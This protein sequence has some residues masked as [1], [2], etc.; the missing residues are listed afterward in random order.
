MTDL[1]DK[2][3]PWGE[4]GCVYRGEDDAETKQLAL[5]KGNAMH[6]RRP[7]GSQ[8]NG[9]NQEKQ[10]KANYWGPLDPFIVSRAECTPEITG[11]VTGGSLAM[12]TPR[13]EKARSSVKRVPHELIPII[14][15]SYF[16]SNTAWVAGSRSPDSERPTSGPARG[17]VAPYS[18]RPTSGPARGHVAP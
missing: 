14:L 9:R 11:T 1:N 16:C 13:N 5:L 4:G 8:R 6:R 2:K 10:W 12:C 7:V 15:Q 17:H 3:Q 18:E